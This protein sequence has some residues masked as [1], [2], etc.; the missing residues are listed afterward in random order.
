MP[1]IKY[2][3]AYDEN[4][5]CINIGDVSKES[6]DAMTFHCISCG[7]E[8]SACLGNK[9]KHYFR[10]KTEVT[11]NP[12]TY[13]HKM[14]KIVFM[15]CYKDCLEHQKPFKITLNRKVT[16]VRSQ[17]C[18][19]FDDRFG[20][21]ES[22]SEIR[23]DEK[24]LTAYYKT[25]SEEKPFGDFIPDIL[26]E[27]EHNGR[28]LYLFV[29]IKVSH[30]CEERKIQ[31]EYPIIEIELDDESDL[32][33]IKTCHLIQPQSDSVFSYNGWS[34]DN[35]LH[36]YNFKDFSRQE[37]LNHVQ[38]IRFILYRESLK[39]CVPPNDFDCGTL[40]KAIEKHRRNGSLAYEVFLPKRYGYK[41][42]FLFG[43]AK[44]FERG[45]DIRNCFLCRFYVEPTMEDPTGSHRPVFCKLYKKLNT[46]QP[47]RYSTDAMSCNSYRP[48]LQICKDYTSYV[49][50]FVEVVF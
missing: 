7:T 19:L 16:C 13:L 11:C 47:Y 17:T 5:R 3:H 50:D 37:E 25:I 22:C 42:A 29:E 8:M 35:K 49:T 21:D 26:L 38:F 43:L 10:H 24:D 33:L 14:G 31:S 45:F 34:R 32:D 39:G 23:Q 12:E 27:G 28:K 40:Y 4:N 6:R 44:A 18:Q 1:D 48:D 20:I 30:A 9:R 15:E 36:F 41:F 46:P 2:Q